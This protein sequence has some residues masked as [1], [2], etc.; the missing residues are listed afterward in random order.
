MEGACGNTQA[1][2]ISRVSSPLRAVEKKSQHTFKLGPGEGLCRDCRAL[3]EAAAQVRARARSRAPRGMLQHH[4]QLFSAALHCRAPLTSLSTNPKLLL[5]SLRLPN[6]FHAAAQGG[7]RDGRGHGRGQ[8]GRG[9]GCRAAQG[10]PQLPPH[11]LLPGPDCRAAAA[12]GH[13][14]ASVRGGLAAAA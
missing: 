1:S 12:A 7:G 6:Y 2:Q 4:W 13:G 8:G 14:A 9:R 11:S 3:M 10:R 5:R